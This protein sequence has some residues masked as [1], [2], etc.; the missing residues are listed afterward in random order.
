MGAVSN[1]PLVDKLLQNDTYKERYH[2]YI[3]QIVEG[4]LSP[5]RL[6]ARAQ[7]I[8][9]MIDTYVEQDPTKFYTYEEFKQ[10]LTSDVKNIPGLLT[11]AE[12][13]V[14]NL[15]QQLDGT[16]LPMIKAKA[17]REECR[18]GA[19]WELLPAMARCRERASRRTP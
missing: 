14:S 11:F 1:Y 8:A 18:A 17:S 19:A 3:Q 13:R 4:Y 2:Q 12:A 9:D 10:S 6:K 7:E 5:V 16:L 15:K